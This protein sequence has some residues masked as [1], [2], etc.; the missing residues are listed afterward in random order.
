M[1]QLGGTSLLD[2]AVSGDVMAVAAAA[3]DGVEAV[4][5]DCL[6]DV[7]RLGGLSEGKSF[8]ALAV[9]GMVVKE[10]AAS[11]FAREDA[12]ST[13]S[14][15]CLWGLPE[16]ICRRSLLPLHMPSVNCCCPL[17]QLHVLRSRPSA[18]P[19]L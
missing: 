12:A 8:I 10:I 15:S 13:K 14:G 16:L 17:K 9:M 5:L 4:L 19:D 18:A 7:N 3:M 6:R 1:R 11:G 2:A